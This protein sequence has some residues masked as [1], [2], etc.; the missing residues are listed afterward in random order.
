MSGFFLQR[1][2]LR[3]RLAV[4]PCSSDSAAAVPPLL[5]AALVGTWPPE[6]AFETASTVRRLPLPPSMGSRLPPEQLG[7]TGLRGLVTAAAHLGLRVRPERRLNGRASSPHESLSRRHGAGASG[8]WAADHRVCDRG[9]GGSRGW[10]PDLVPR[11]PAGVGRGRDRCPRDRRPPY[12]LPSR[13]PG[14]PPLAEWC[15]DQDS[16]RGSSTDGLLLV[17]RIQRS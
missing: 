9:A 7:Q 15:R 11:E 14:A 12:L 5:T 6:D 3:P 2:D 17:R 1:T 16:R 10:V 4:H 8:A 13:L